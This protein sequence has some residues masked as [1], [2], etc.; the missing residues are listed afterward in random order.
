MAEWRY[1]HLFRPIRER[2]RV[3]S[4]FSSPPEKISTECQR[5][6]NHP[7]HTIST[8]LSPLP[9]ERW[10]PLQDPEDIPSN[11]MRVP[12]E[13][14]K[15]GL[16][17]DL[18]IILQDKKG[19]K[20]ILV[21]KCQRTAF[22]R[23]EHKTMLHLKGHRVHHEL[24]RSYFWPHMAKEIKLLCSECSICQQALVKRQNLPHFQASRRKGPSSS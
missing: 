24:S 23:T 15:K 16:P 11:M 5:I 10:A 7:L 4:D 1:N 22:T 8:V 14:I 17:L 19:H 20:R 12:K 21:P 2:G 6:L 18:I 3:Q 13:E 9:I